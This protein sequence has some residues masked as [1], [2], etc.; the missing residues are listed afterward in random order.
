MRS[1]IAVARAGADAQAA[2]RRVFDRL[3]AQVIH[4]D[5]PLRSFD[6]RF[7]E[8]DEIRA[9]A[10]ELAARADG[11]QRGIDRRG[12]LVFERIHDHALRAAW[13]I[14]ATIFGYAPQRQMLP[15]MR[16]RISV[17]VSSGLPRVS[18]VTA[19]GAPRRNSSS[20]A[21]PEQSCPGVQ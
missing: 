18:H 8:I 20:I 11:A 9:S 7:H 6:A 17:S 15:L 12:A 19:L 16:S 3:Q 1:D 10:D 14:A 5:E 21:V 2:L 4:I 13:R